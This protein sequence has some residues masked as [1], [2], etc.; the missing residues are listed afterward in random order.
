VPVALTTARRQ[1][2]SADRLVVAV[3]VMANAASFLLPTSNITSLLLLGQQLCQQ[4]REHLGLQPGPGT[5]A[6]PDRNPA[7]SPVLR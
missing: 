2:L 1:G 3:A 7:I 5:A 4:A 6:L